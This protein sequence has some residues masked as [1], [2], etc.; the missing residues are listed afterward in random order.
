MK[1][2]REKILELVNAYERQLMFYEQIREVGSQEKDLIAKGDLESLLKVLRQ[3][4]VYL[5]NATG[6]ETEIKSLQA[7][8]TRHFQLDEFSIP[9]L[10]S[11]ASDRYQ[12]DFEQLESVINKLVPMLE[13]LENQERR[14]EQSLSRYIDATKVQ[15]P[16]R[17]QIKLARTAYEKKK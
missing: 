2:I 6:Q 10:K 12:G 4:G 5:K 14:N 1:E 15:T 7:L 8:L 16:G 13:E 11:K 9:Q 3:K 17:P